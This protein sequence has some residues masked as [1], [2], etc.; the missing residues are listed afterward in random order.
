MKEQVNLRRRL[1]AL[2]GKPENQS[3]CDCSSKK[4]TWAT[5][6]KIRCDGTAASCTIGAFCCFQCSGAHRSLGTHI[7]FVR[8]VDL[9]VCK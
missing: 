5:L 2:M 6:L 3:C 1:R 7:T 9:D 8:S 4:P